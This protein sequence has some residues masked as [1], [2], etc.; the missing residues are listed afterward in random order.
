[1][2]QTVRTQ[3]HPA[4]IRLLAQFGTAFAWMP[5]L[6]TR[7]ELRREYVV[8]ESLR[9]ERLASI[10]SSHIYNLRNSSTYRTQRTVWN[11]T[12]PTNNSIGLR[13]AP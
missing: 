7:E 12:R 8:H 6:A 3:V 13:Q 11:H 5:A 10:L 9:F 2:R 1:M 4:D